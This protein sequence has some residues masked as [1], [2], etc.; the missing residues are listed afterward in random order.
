MNQGIETEISRNI[1]PAESAGWIFITS[2]YF[3]VETRIP[4]F[5]PHLQVMKPPQDQ[6][7]VSEIDQRSITNSFQLFNHFQLKCPHATSHL[8]L[9]NPDRSSLEHRAGTKAQV[10]QVRGWHRPILAFYRAS[11][12][13]SHLFFCG[14]W[15]TPIRNPNMTIKK[16]YERYKRSKSSPNGR[17]MALDLPHNF[18]TKAS[19]CGVGSPESLRQ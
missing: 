8:F 15:Y 7:Q 10:D 2:S 4:E 12:Q 3:G 6:P 1:I 19:N 14:K 18:S 9:I 16:W 13:Q 17:F 5:R 11:R